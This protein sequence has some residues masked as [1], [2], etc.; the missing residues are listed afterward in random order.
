[1]MRNA[2]TIVAAMLGGRPVPGVLAVEFTLT[3]PQGNVSP[4]SGVRQARNGAAAFD[5]APAVNDPAGTW[6][7]TATELV[8]GRKADAAVRVSGR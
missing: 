8:T 6:T 5:W 3:N 7:M 4:V 2:V 1:M